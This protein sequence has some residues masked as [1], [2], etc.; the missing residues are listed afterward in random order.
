MY[1]NS[2]VTIE[3][4]RVDFQN[5]DRCKSAYNRAYGIKFGQMKGVTSTLLEDIQRIVGF[6]HR[7]VHVSPMIGMLNRG[8]VPPEEPIFPKHEYAEK[9]ISVF[10]NFINCLHSATLALIP[11]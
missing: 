7:I 9:A 6:R 4:G 2:A 10:D 8:S 5:Y 1:F 3:K 11:K